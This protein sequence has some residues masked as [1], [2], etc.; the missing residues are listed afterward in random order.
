MA[1]EGVL[2]FH[3]ATAFASD[4]QRNVAFYVEVLGLRLVKR[5]VNQDAPEVYHLFYADA[6]G[7][8]GTDITF[9]PWR[10]I[11]SPQEG[12][13]LVREIWLA[14]PAASLISGGIIFSYGMLMRWRFY[15]GRDPGATNLWATGF[16]AA[17]M[18]GVGGYQ[19]TPGASY[20]GSAPARFCGQGGTQADRFAPSYT[21]AQIARPAE[22]AVI[23]DALGFDYGMTCRNRYPAPADALDAS[24]PYRGLN[25]AGRYAYEGERL[26]QGVP[27]RLGVGAV[28]FADGHVAGMRTERLFTIHADYEPHPQT[29]A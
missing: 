8:P 22:V 10:N 26:Y 17:M 1:T 5:S 6:V 16:G 14:A 25:F 21:F 12:A 9:F 29:C 4:A 3:H 13:G 18:D 20:F 11:A 23:A 27:Y 7:S 19:F 24:S 28:G 15:S 2:G